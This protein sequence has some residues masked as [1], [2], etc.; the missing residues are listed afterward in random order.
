[1]SRGSDTVWGIHCDRS[2]VRET[3]SQRVTPFVKGVSVAEEGPQSISVVTRDTFPV[4]TVV[5][6]ILTGS[7]EGSQPSTGDTSTPL[8]LS[9]DS[10]DEFH[11]PPEPDRTY[12]KRESE[13][14]PS[15]VG[16]WRGTCVVLGH[17]V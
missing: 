14:I 9:P 12:L 8:T 13:K 10:S 2:M 5:V 1:M 3:R 17:T 16:S 15:D 4:E 6:V 11:S 7:M